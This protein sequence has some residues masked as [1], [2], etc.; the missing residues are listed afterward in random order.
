MEELALEVRMSIRLFFG[1]EKCFGP[2]PAALLEATDRLG[3]LRA[4]AAEADMAYSKA[5]TSLRACEQAL[6]FPLLEREA[7]GRRGGGSRL[8]PLGRDLLAG[9]RE[10]EQRMN[11]EGARLLLEL[12]PQLAMVE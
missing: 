1:G 5:W 7:G 11:E 8:T 4:A 10:L 3:S 6:G 9:Y 2:G 12:L